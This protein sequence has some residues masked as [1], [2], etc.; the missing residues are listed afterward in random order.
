MYPHTDDA[1][2]AT[3]ESAKTLFE[4]VKEQG[5]ASVPSVLEYIE[6]TE[7]VE[8]SGQPR[9]LELEG[10]NDLN[11]LTPLPTIAPSSAPTCGF[12]RATRLGRSAWAFL[13]KLRR[14]GRKP[15]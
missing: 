12:A 15:T 11:N 9:E 1:S 4:D 2:Q 14:Y 13:K 7:D 6:R 3:H 8:G 10:S 5:E